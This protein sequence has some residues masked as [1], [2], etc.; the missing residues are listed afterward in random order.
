MLTPTVNVTANNS[1]YSGSAYTVS[2]VNVVGQNN[3][4]LASLTVDPSTL[5][6]SWYVG[7]GTSG[8]NLGSNAPKDAGTYTVVAHYISD[9]AGYASADSTPET[10]TITP[11]TVLVTGL[12]ATNKIYDA[13]NADPLSGT[14]ALLAAEAAGRA[15]NS[16]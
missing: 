5:S 16:D 12:S 4:T 9:Q 13:T 2:A 10:F 7:T 14:A 6:F 8:T 11:K 1:I 3:T 15:R